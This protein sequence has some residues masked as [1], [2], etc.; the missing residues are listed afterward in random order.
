MRY[1]FVLFYYFSH[2]NNGHLYSCRPLSQV[3]FSVC[4]HPPSHLKDHLCGKEP[5]L[6][7]ELAS[8]LTE[9]TQLNKSENSKVALRARQVLIA[10][11]LPPYEHRHNQMESIFLSAIDMSGHDF[12]PENLQV[13]FIFIFLV[14]FWLFPFTFHNDSGSSSSEE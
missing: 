1:C 8:L 13:R 11:H 3:F 7:D 10:A 6:T 2:S 4:P 14:Y 9:L 5:G 12:S